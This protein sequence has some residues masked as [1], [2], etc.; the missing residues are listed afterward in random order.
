M[1][2]AGMQKIRIG[3]RAKFRAEDKCFSSGFISGSR[4]FRQ[5]LTS[6]LLDFDFLHNSQLAFGYYGR[7]MP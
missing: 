3:H 1:N 5:Y 7:I 6:G 2:G 4:D